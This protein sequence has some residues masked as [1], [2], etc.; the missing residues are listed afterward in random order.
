MPT[1][2]ISTR[3]KDRTS[4]RAAK[5]A[6]ESCPRKTRPASSKT[7]G[8]SC[9]RKSRASSPCRSKRSR[10]SKTPCARLSQTDRLPAKDRDDLNNGAMI[11]R[12]V[13]G[14]INNRDEGI[15]ARI[16]RIL[17]DQRNFKIDNPDAQKQLEDMLA[18]L[19]VIREQHLG[20]A[21]Q[22]LT[23]ATK[24]LDAKNALRAE[25]QPVS[26]RPSRQPKPESTVSPNRCGASRPASGCPSPS[27]STVEA[28]AETHQGGAN[29]ES[30]QRRQ[31][32]GRRVEGQQREGRGVQGKQSKGRCVEGQQR[33]GRVGQGRLEARSSSRRLRPSRARTQ[34]SSRWPSRR[35]TRRR[36]PTSCRRCSTA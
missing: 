6:C 19:A 14:R 12:Q 17:D 32:D 10:R 29:A 9:V 16:T 20:P 3:S 36:L 31:P 11:Q 5:F 24:S 22:G 26:G 7:R 15:G 28:K 35:R 1:P 25:A 27:R 33:S 2:A 18:R 13:S 34:L 4:A 8:A 30:V 23:R 21:E